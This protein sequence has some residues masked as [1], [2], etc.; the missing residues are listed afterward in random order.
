MLDEILVARLHPGAASSAPPL[1]PIGRNW[2]SLEIAAVADRDRDLLVGDQVF[3]MDLGSFVFNPRAALIAVEFFNFFELLQD[4]KST[5]LNS[6]HRCIS[7]AVFC[8]K[9]KNK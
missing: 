9:K 7:Y 1:H 8:L 6:S 4:R 5:R 3:E 2:C